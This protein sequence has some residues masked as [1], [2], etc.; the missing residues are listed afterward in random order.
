LDLERVVRSPLAAKILRRI[1]FVLWNITRFVVAT[2][3]PTAMLV[4]QNVQAL[5]NIP[6]V[7][8]KNPADIPDF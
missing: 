4:L 8:A 3:K 5:L 7:P 1:A 2:T 6:K